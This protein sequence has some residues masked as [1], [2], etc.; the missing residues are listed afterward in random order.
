MHV[1][2]IH[3]C[4]HVCVCCVN[5]CVCV[6]VCVLVNMRACYEHARSGVLCYLVIDT[7][8]RKAAPRKITANHV[9]NVNGIAS[10]GNNVFK[11]QMVSNGPK[12]SKRITKATINNTAIT[13]SLSLVV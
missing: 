7:F 12:I 10:T 4:V 8:A 3:T 11:L 5:V 1:L 2:S 6:T 9:Q 13:Y